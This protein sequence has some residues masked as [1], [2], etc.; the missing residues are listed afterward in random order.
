MMS[1]L[2]TRKGQAFLF[3]KGAPEQ[4]LERCVSALT[5]DGGAAEPMTNKARDALQTRLASFARAVLC[6]CWRW[7]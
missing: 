2:A 7:R 1:V 6:A 4:V 5:A 3:T